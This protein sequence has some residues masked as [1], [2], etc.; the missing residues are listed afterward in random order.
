MPVVT[1]LQASGANRRNV[2]A[3]DAS[4]RGSGE[5]NELV[6]PSVVSSERRLM[7]PMQVEDQPVS[8]LELR[9]RGRRTKRLKWL[10]CSLLFVIVTIGITLWVLLSVSVTPME[11]T[12][13]TPLSML[14]S[15]TPLLP[16]HDQ[17]VPRRPLVAR[18]LRDFLCDTGSWVVCRNQ[19]ARECIAFRQTAES[20]EGRIIQVYET[21]EVDA[22]VRR[23]CAPFTIFV[24]Y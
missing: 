5:S 24:K 9:R 4:L 18:D 17:V 20:P 21:Q 14:P 11:Y 16:S 15:Q 1:R 13:P 2:V 6:T 19:F 12:Q 3:V 23:A 7:D 8:G 10:C 22:E